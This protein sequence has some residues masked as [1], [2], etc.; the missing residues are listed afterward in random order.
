MANTFYDLSSEYVN[1]WQE[2]EIKESEQAAVDE[3]ADKIIA[4]RERYEQVSAKTGVPWYFIG[5]V[6]NRESGMNFTKHLHNGDS[7]KARTRRDPPGHPKKGTP[8]FTWEESAED[9]LRIKKLQNIKEW[10]VDRLAYEFERFNGFGYRNNTSIKSPY[11]WAK[12]N[13]YTRGKYIRDHVYSVN[14][15]DQQIGCMVLFKAIVDKCDDVSFEHE[16]EKPNYKDVVK[17]SNT[18]SFFARVRMALISF[19]GLIAGLF[20]WE[21]AMNVK[22]FLS[23]KTGWILAA[24]GIMTAIYVIM[25]KQTEKKSVESLQKGEWALNKKGKK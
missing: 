7:L 3:T 17:D 20:S 25:S 18:L 6:H 22:T 12:S 8:P 23:D 2:M 21:S 14:A 5:I 4:N 10:T 11:L 19:W 15:V 24:I 13:H 1:L 9:A 16:E